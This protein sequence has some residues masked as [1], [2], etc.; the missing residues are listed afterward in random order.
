M[1]RQALIEVRAELAVEPGHEPIADAAD[2]MRRQLQDE[3]GEETPIQ[4]LFQSWED[5]RNPSRGSDAAFDCAG[6][7]GRAGAFREPV[8]LPRGP[9]AA[10][11]RAKDSTGRAVDSVESHGYA[12]A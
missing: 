5:A 9:R 4:V 7:A 8:V 12:D 2:Q 11:E 10:V 6:L 3:T 1:A